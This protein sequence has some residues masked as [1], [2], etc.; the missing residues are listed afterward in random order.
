VDYEV[1]WALYQ[2]M[3]EDEKRGCVAEA[4][5]VPKPDEVPVTRRDGTQGYIYL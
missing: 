4:L 5:Y 1:E 3:K 2:Q